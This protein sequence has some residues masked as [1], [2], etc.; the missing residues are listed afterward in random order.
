MQEQIEIKNKQLSLVLSKQGC[1]MQQLSVKGLASPLMSLLPLSEGNLPKSYSG[2]TIGPLCGRT[3]QGTITIGKKVYQLTQNEKGNHL[4]GGTHSLSHF[5]WEIE[6]QSGASVQMQVFLPDGTDGYPGNRRVH[7]MYTLCD[8]SIVITLRAFTDKPTFFNITNHAYW[9][10]NSDFSTDIHA[11]VFHF[12]ASH[13]F[14]NDGDFLPLEKAPV[15]GT[16]FDFTEPRS[17]LDSLAFCSPKEQIANAKGI[18]HGFCTDRAE[19][20]GN[21]ASLVV[22]SDAPDLWF[23]SGGFLGKETQLAN[24]SF[25]HPSC[26]FAL[27]PQQVINQEPTYPC[28]QYSRTIT[29]TLLT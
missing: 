18:N 28:Q 11:H 5:H 9:N 21:T 10:L 2:Y 19:V 4:H 8:H 20:S 16:S 3:R 15:K 23:Y 24:G 7:C 13:Y 27:E 17:F 14:L 26:A 22:E 12:P 6:N 25:A 1:S 29:Y